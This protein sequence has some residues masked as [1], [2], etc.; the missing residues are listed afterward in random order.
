MQ[1]LEGRSRCGW[2]DQVFWKSTQNIAKAIFHFAA[3]ARSRRF[4]FRTHLT[5]DIVLIGLESA[6]IVQQVF[7]MRGNLNAAG[8]QLTAA[9][10]AEA[11][12]VEEIAHRVSTSTKFG[13]IRALI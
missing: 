11:K 5:Q 9:L 7:P 8:E 2:R 4:Q 3:A 10:G 12:K 1:I 13:N 6:N